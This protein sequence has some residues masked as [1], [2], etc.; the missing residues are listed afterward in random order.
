MTSSRA[1]VALAEDPERFIEPPE[2]SRQIL[3]DSYCAVIGPQS[4][5]AG[6]CS[7]RLSDLGTDLERVFTEI[8]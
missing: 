6:V 3:T 1:L 7:L 8:K 5:W 2:G 4:R